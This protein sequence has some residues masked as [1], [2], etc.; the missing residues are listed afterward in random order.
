MQTKTRVLRVL[1]SNICSPGRTR[2]NTHLVSKRNNGLTVG[3]K[4]DKRMDKK[5]RSL[6]EVKCAIYSP[7]LRLLI[8]PHLPML[9]YRAI[10]HTVGGQK[11][12]RCPSVCTVGVFY[13]TSHHIVKAQVT[14]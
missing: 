1:R 4:P 12:R 7:T 14:S 10:D 11:P 13:H 6:L 2:S 5:V 3:D 8:L 9:H